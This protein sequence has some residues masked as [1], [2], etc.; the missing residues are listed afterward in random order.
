MEFNRHISRR[1]HEEHAATLALWG[2]VEQTLAAGKPDPALLRQAATMLAEEIT[3]HFEFEEAQLFP[4][5]AAAGEGDISALL[6]DEHAAIRTAARG[7]TA[8]VKQD[9]ADPALRPLALE[10]AERLVS[11]VQKEEMALLPALDELLDEETDHELNAAY[12]AA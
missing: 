12:A 3:R 4:R 10:L 2:R 8:L 1:L 9:A 6:L 5:L 7:Y 11:H